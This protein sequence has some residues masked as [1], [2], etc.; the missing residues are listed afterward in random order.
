MD[1]LLPDDMLAALR[2]SVDLV[3]LIGRDITLTELGDGFV[4]MC[5]FGC[6]AKNFG[7]SRTHQVYHCFGCG[8]GGNAFK[9]VQ[10]RRGL[11]FAESV[12]FLEGA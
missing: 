9:Y 12:H 8:V 11:S 2:E 6:G 7:V 4:G 5:P 1:S 10:D 3:E